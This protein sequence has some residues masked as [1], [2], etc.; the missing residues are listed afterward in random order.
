MSSIMEKTDV[1]SSKHSFT[2]EP[3]SDEVGKAAEIVDT[4]ENFYDDQGDIDNPE[5][6]AELGYKQEFRRQL[7]LFGIFSISFSVLGMLPSVASTLVFGLWYVGYPGLLWA[8]LIA[9]FFLICV[10]MSMAE[11]CSAMPTSGGLYY[12]AA[13][14]APK[15]WG[16]LASWI[17]G[18]SNYIGNIIGQPSVNSSAASMILGAV[19]VNRPDF[20]IQRWQWFLLA[21]AIQCFNCVLACLPTRIISRINGVATYLNTA[22]LFIAGI[23]ILAYG[24]KNHNFVKGTKI[25]GDYINTTQWPTGFA[26]L[27]SFNSPIWTMSGYDA[28]FHLSEECSNAS[29]NAPKAIVMTA[30]IGGVVGWIMQIIVAY[31]LTDIDSVMNTSGSMWTAYLVQAMPPKAALGILSLTIISAIIM[32]QSAL[33]ASSRIA[34][35]YARDGILPFSGWIG[36]VNP[37]TQ[38]PVNAVICNCIISILILF[39]TFAGTV[40]LDA[41]FSVGAVAAF[42][43]FTVPIAIRVFFTKDADFRRGPW[44]LGK[45]SR[46]I[47]LLAVSFVALMIPILCFPS[48]KNPTAQEMNWTCLVYGGPMLFTLVW[49]A[50]SA[51]KWFKGPKAS[52]HYKRPGEESS[53]IVEGVQADIPSSSDQLKIKGDL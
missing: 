2:F 12:A 24:G 51:R 30:V 15:G 27:L 21:V 41:V 48:V 33:I 35:S 9:M 26:I 42:I 19:T 38:T 52:A 31:T 7:S 20:V 14:F 37:Y 53:D 10:S 46:P 6:L 4:H 47:G 23:T 11:I 45:F 36:T 22:F 16:P 18:W 34:Y 25:W 39:L 49:Y 32:G 43:A 17:T 44:N 5:E 1:S 40:T 8:W 29:V 50:I 28:P 3:S 13:V